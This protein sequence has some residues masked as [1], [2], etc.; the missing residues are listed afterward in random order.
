LI[1]GQV[2]ESYNVG[3]GEERLNLDLVKAICDLVDLIEGRADG[4]S[5]RLIE[6]VVDRPGH[7]RR[8]AID[9]RKISRE[10]G[11][12]PNVSLDDGL[13]KTVLWYRENKAW[14]APIVRDKY[15]RS[16]LGLGS[17]GFGGD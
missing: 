3:T 13:R 12:R 9:S 8:Y 16:R 2:G 10:L 14:W 15:D 5:R 17:R 4:T 7:D 11:W 6:H 1:G